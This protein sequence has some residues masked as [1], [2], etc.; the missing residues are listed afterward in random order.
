MFQTALT[1]I[2]YNP[3][4]VASIYK[5]ELNI[6]GDKVFVEKKFG[7]K[8][9]FSKLQFIQIKNLLPYIDRLNTVEL[10]KYS[11]GELTDISNKLLYCINN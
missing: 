11:V 10:T 2:S 7:I 5:K 1:S 3:Q 6:I 4:D 8:H 9:K